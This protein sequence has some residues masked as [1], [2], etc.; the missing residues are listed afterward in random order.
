MTDEAETEAVD[1]DNT[2]IQS[3]IETG[4][5]GL[6]LETAE[7]EIETNP[8]A[9]VTE[10]DIELDTITADDALADILEEKSEE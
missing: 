7:I 6:D 5:E 4:A 9:L 2:E 10:S 8:D 3:E 1:L